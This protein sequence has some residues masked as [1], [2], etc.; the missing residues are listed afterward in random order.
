MEKWKTLKSKYVHKS[1]FGNIRRDSCE[2]PNGMVID[3]YYVNEYSDWVNGVVI[4]REQ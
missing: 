2:L 4:T 3:D 1:R